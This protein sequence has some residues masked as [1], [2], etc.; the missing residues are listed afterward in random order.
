MKN[1]KLEASKCGKSCISPRKACRLVASPRA[2]EFLNALT[3]A[4]QATGENK[5][6]WQNI[7][8]MQNAKRDAFGKTLPDPKPSSGAKPGNLFPSFD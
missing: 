2:G 8:A 1:C 3:V 4:R 6:I 7:V 5:K